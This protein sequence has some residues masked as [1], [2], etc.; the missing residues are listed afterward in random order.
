MEEE[1]IAESGS[2]IKILSYCDE[3]KFGSEDKC[4]EKICGQPYQETIRADLV[5]H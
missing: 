1:R 3:V 4:T 5:E 2:R